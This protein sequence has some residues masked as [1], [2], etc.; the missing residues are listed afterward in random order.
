[1]QNMLRITLPGGGLTTPGTRRMVEHVFGLVQRMKANSL[2]LTPFSASQAEETAQPA[3]W[4]P[5]AAQTVDAGF[6]AGE[7]LQVDDLLTEARPTTTTLPPAA[8]PPAIE[9]Q[10]E[11][12]ARPASEPPGGK[13]IAE[14]RVSSQPASVPGVQRDAAFLP[15]QP[16][17]LP[18]P[19]QTPPPGVPVA[20]NLSK[21]DVK[22]NTLLRQ[23]LDELIRR[24]AEEVTTDESGTN[25]TIVPGSGNPQEP[26]SETTTRK[27]DAPLP[28]PYPVPRAGRRNWKEEFTTPG[29]QPKPSAPQSESTQPPSEP[30]QRAYTD[31]MRSEIN[32][33]QSINDQPE[34]AP[35]PAGQPA[36]QMPLQRERQQ[37]PTLESPVPEPVQVQPPTPDSELVQPEQP[38]LRAVE[39][40]PT[41]D[42][43]AG[44]GDE[45]TSP[46]E[47]KP[48]GVPGQFFAPP[49]PDIPI[50]RNLSAADIQLNRLMRRRLDELQRKKAATDQTAPQTEPNEG[51]LP[52]QQIQ[53]QGSETDKP[54]I[55]QLA[56][57]GPAPSYP[58]P[59]PAR[60]RAWKEEFTSPERKTS[61]T[62]EIGTSP[63]P[64]VQR[65]T[66]ANIPVIQP[67]EQSP[68]TR[69][70]ERL[71][72]EQT[73]PVKPSLLTDEPSQAT[74]RQLEV[75]GNTA[76]A[77]PNL[78]REAMQPRPVTEPAP[79]SNP[80]ITP[81]TA[82]AV[83]RQVDFPQ[84]AREA[85]K[86]KPVTKA[87]SPAPAPE[88]ETTARSSAP[89][90]TDEPSSQV[91][92][93]SQQTPS[94]EGKPA[95]QI[96][97]SP[98]PSHSLSRSAEPAPETTVSGVVES[99]VQPQ[100]SPV[101]QP[102]QEQSDAAGEEDL[103]PANQTTPEA[104]LE[105]QRQVAQLPLTVL[106]DQ[107]STGAQSPIES[108]DSGQTSKATRRFSPAQ[109]REAGPTGQANPQTP[110]AQSSGQPAVIARLAADTANEPTPQKPAVR[111]EPP[112]SGES[113]SPVEEEIPAAP[114]KL[115]FLSQTPSQP[116]DQKSP[117][118]E[119]SLPVPDIHATQATEQT[120]ALTRDPIGVDRVSSGS[121]PSDPEPKAQPEAPALPA[122]ETVQREVSPQGKAPVPP[123]PS[124]GSLETAD[125]S[126]I[127]ADTTPSQ[128]KDSSPSTVEDFGIREEQAT[129]SGPVPLSEQPPSP[130]AEIL[131]PADT[132]KPAGIPG[133]QLQL[134]PEI[135][136]QP[137]PDQVFRSAEL[138]TEAP[139]TA[140]QP[141]QPVQA[142]Q[143]ALE[144]TQESA[145]AQEQN[146]PA[147]ATAQTLPT[148]RPSVSEA[149]GQV[150][151]A[152][153]EPAAPTPA[154]TKLSSS[155][156]PQREML[157]AV[158][159]N[160][161]AR[162]LNS[163]QEAAAKEAKEPNPEPGLAPQTQSTQTSPQPSPA[164]FSQV[165]RESFEASATAETGT[166]QAPEPRELT[167]EE[168]RSLA[169]QVY[170]LVRR[171]IALEKERSSGRGF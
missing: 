83:D 85:E 147:D 65:E 12:A 106:P 10:P 31:D 93:A 110:T 97:E 121:E 127:D 168:L 91:P 71:P 70:E 107:P 36:H 47:H 100:A 13:P 89:F 62:G 23:R 131:P 155:P 22:I 8:L 160:M 74:E 21:A 171:L 80:D 76:A 149:A 19:A 113:G 34:P 81:E 41:Q 11:A 166:E 146:R 135:E 44:P 52:R 122:G 54:V 90:Q 96:E 53:A 75:G 15:T 69:D 77:S 137:M 109:A 57:T 112:S 119:E 154:E 88:D 51:P 133:E 32:S 169:R 118:R 162:S 61:A 5:A 17:E 55:A 68:A 58:A 161:L 16:S 164:L 103:P 79:P 43:L 39:T 59:R 120:L 72:E 14:R 153:S 141:M 157:T 26:P 9:Q 129:Q 50:A 7:T 156:L 87:V 128:P 114:D 115:V 30:V 132:S 40:A 2:D 33:A 35:L 27:L 3:T 111:P 24:R 125:R 4:E 148:A 108:L 145:P 6:P 117:T 144:A 56:E 38:V 152:A 163:N 64:P 105:N 78:E 46:V 158:L 102:L 82:P 84:I 170:P 95:P 1:M 167:P 150:L 151:R 99:C 142:N 92:S 49:S 140:E 86:S 63:E 37:E 104:I 45:T 138:E 136:T 139:D 20:R 124:T 101:V 73:L 28:A 116:P 18:P 159:E 98:A 60:R 123:A 165:Q 94:T 126:S 48:A 143:K 134:Q 67:K 25:E 29:S 42:Q 130:S 66:S